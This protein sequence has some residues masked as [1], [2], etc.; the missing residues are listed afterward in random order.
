MMKKY[1]VVATTL[2]GLTLAMPASAQFSSDAPILLKMLA[3]SL[4]QLAQ[5]YKVVETT[6]ANVAM[7]RE[8]NSGLEDIRNLH[9]DLEATVSPGHLKNWLEVGDSLAKL[10]RIYGSPSSTLAGAVQKDLDLGIA[11]AVQGSNAAFNLSKRSDS[12][13]KGVGQASAVA[14]PK[15]AQ[16]LTAQSL[17]VLIQVQSQSVRTAGE[18]LRLTAQALARENYHDKMDSQRIAEDSLHLQQSL[19]NSKTSFQLPRL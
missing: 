5:L 7:L 1:L 18:H 6:R 3:N 17:G 10:E 19:K 2:F 13:A 11:E 9:Q 14:S 8:I 12:F 16:R 4:T 15:G